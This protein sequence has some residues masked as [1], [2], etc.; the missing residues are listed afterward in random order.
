MQTRITPKSALY[1]FDSAREMGTFARDAARTWRYTEA[2]G[3]PA[4]A[5]WDLNTTYAQ[6]VEL[7]RMGWLEGARKSQRALKAFTPATPEPETRNDFYGYRPNVALYCA[8]EPACMVRHAREAEQS[9]R[10]VLT[11][12]VP[13]AANAYTDARCMAN[14]GVAIAQYVAQ[15][16]AQGTR[17]ELL[18]SLPGTVSGWRVCFTWTVKQSDQPL[19][20]SQVAFSIGHPACFRRLGFALLERCAA[21]EASNYGQ[22]RDLEPADVPNLPHDAVILNG[23]AR[24]NE[25]APTPQAGL[26]CVERQIE[27]AMAKLAKAR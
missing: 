7:A 6:A 21:P 3:I 8:G 25:Y 10:A 5:S 11:L 26:E 12:V 14:F 20:L 1:R 22:S 2:Q 15:L 13:I 17:V 18:A 23:M 16:E 27:A 19:D 4:S 24:A 9:R